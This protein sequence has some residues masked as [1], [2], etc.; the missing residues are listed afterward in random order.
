MFDLMPGG[1]V[2]YHVYQLP[3]CIVE[4]IKCQWCATDCLSIQVCALQL[5]G[6]QFGVYATSRTE[7][8]WIGSSNTKGEWCRIWLYA[9]GHPEEIRTAP[10]KFHLP[11]R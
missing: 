7:S 9:L 4:T 10:S 1:L 5:T 3:H 11:L 2:I 6:D 8:P